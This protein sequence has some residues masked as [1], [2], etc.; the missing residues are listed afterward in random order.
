MAR[1]LHS[2]VSLVLFGTLAGVFVVSLILLI[3]AVGDSLMHPIRKH[4]DGGGFV[5]LGV[6]VFPATVAAVRR[7]IHVL[8]EHR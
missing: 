8:A 1:P 5:L 7:F 6:I 3:L 4:L 2:V